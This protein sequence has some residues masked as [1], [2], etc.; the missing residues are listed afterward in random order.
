MTSILSKW[1]KLHLVNQLRTLHEAHRGLAYRGVV[2]SR[3]D[4]VYGVPVALSRLTFTE[5]VSTL[6]EEVL[7]MPLPPVRTGANWRMCLD[8]QA[9]VRSL[10]CGE[11]AST[12]ACTDS[13]LLHDERTAALAACPCCQEIH[14]AA[15]G[16]NLCS[17]NVYLNTTNE[18]AV[19]WL[20]KHIGDQLVLG[21][22]PAIDVFSSMHQESPRLFDEEATMFVGSFA[23]ER[24]IAR[25]V[26][27]EL[28]P[29]RSLHLA[30]GRTMWPNAGW[31][32]RGL[33][34]ISIRTVDWVQWGTA[35]NYKSPSCDSASVNVAN[36][37]LRH[38]RRQPHYSGRG[39]LSPC[40]AGTLKYNISLWILSETKITA[41]NNHR[42]RR[43]QLKRFLGEEEDQVARDKPRSSL[44][45]ALEYADWRLRLCDL[46]A[47]ASVTA[48]DFCAADEEEMPTRLLCEA[49]VNCSASVLSA[50]RFLYTPEIC[51]VECDVKPATRT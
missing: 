30:A 22:G 47:N 7:Y 25:R 10:S 14:N 17:C 48:A 41:G 5:G 35:R 50:R 36:R 27:D 37:S 18:D 2:H 6:R 16:R 49:L 46:R 31:R 9:V 19:Q 11:W 13:P 15:L 20:G 33:V 21:S 34:P 42:N 23:P 32:P 43:M 4:L 29:W 38:W 45:V 12:G 1:R 28:P 51:T 44:R 39:R 8:E 3:P 24:S 40:L 26:R